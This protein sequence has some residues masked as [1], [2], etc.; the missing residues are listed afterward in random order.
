ML[1]ALRGIRIRHWF[2]IAVL[3]TFVALIVA[4]RTR[5]LYVV[6]SSGRGEQ[7]WVTVRN[8][9]ASV[10]RFKVDQTIPHFVE[11]SITDQ[12]WPT[13]NWWFGRE[14]FTSGDLIWVPLWVFAVPVVAWLAW[15]VPRAAARGK[16]A[17]LDCGYPIGS[18]SRCTECGR[19]VRR[20][21][22]RRREGSASSRRALS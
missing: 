8:G 3:A 17:C 20:R 5:E 21:G 10:L 22:R 4:S 1:R 16:H 9:R 14:S 11:A 18:S 15:S 12:R 19:P 2:G 13:M 7:Y 6:W